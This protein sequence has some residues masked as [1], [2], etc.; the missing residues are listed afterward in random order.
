MSL[1]SHRL[2]LPLGT[3]VGRYRLDRYLGSGGFGITY[4]AHD[5]RLGRSVAIKELLPSQIASRGSGSTVY[6]NTQSDNDDW[7]WAVKRF[8]EEA[9]MLASF[10]HPNI[11][12]V[13]ETFR[14]NGTVYMVTCYEEGCDMEAWLKGNGRP[15]KEEELEAIL[16]PLLSALEVVHGA[17]FLHRDIKPANIYIARNG[18]PILIDFGSARQAISSRS[19]P[20][21]AIVTPGYAPFE[22]YIETGNQGAWTD[23]YALGAVMYRSV[24]GVRPPES[25]ARAA[26]RKTGDPIVRL[27]D[28]YA[29]RYSAKFLRSIDWALAANEEDRPQTAAEWRE[30]LLGTQHFPAKKRRVVI[31]VLTIAVIA[32][33]GVLATGVSGKYW[34]LGSTGEGE[35][36]RL[37]ENPASSEFAD[38]HGA[39]RSDPGL[40]LPETLQLSRPASTGESDP[41]IEAPQPVINSLGM[42]FVPAGNG[43]VLFSVYE[44]RVQ[45]Y[46]RFRTSVPA[47]ESG[48]VL[49]QVDTSWVSSTDFRWSRPNYEQE[50]DYPVVGVSWKDAVDFCKW[51]TERERRSGKIAS[52]SQF[53]LPTDLEWSRA[54]GLGDETGETPEKRELSAG[55][56]YRYP[57]GSNWPPPANVAN[58]LNA[59]SWPINVGSYPAGKYELHDMCGN[60][61]EWCQDT[62]SPDMENKVLRGG[63]WYPQGKPEKE[64]SLS[65]R[66]SAEP[67]FKSTY[68]GFRVVLENP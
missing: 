1:N 56:R 40:A 44:T 30:C 12:Q 39:I 62:Y 17:G 35:S 14:A 53:R 49:V 28:A 43:K 51:L 47:R 60:V 45:D 11:L 67:G 54:V 46:R 33:L 26:G 48:P 22:Q 6:A 32:V 38:A 15:P 27:S 8:E 19:T 13:Y 10:N 4:L 25:T 55:K 18:R 21:T 58:I 61:W 36:S 20:I 42:E 31:A 63:A 68:I 52:R 7:Q 57:W 50:D 2:G 3:R 59:F 64:Y 34:K 29:G 66:E 5:E 37:N 23:L 9:R 24:T 65:Y 16:L 41:Q